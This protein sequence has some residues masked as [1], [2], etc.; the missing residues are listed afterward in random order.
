MGEQ[1][2]TFLSLDAFLEWEARQT[3][4]HEFV[5][6]VARMMT[7]G[8]LRHSR[9]AGLAFAAFDRRLRG[10][11]CRPTTSDFM[12]VLP[13]G[14]GR[15]PDVTVVC[16]PFDPADRA[17]RSPVAIVEILSPSTAAYDQN[18]ELAAYREI[19][20]LQHVLILHRDEPRADLWT[21]GAA[22]GANGWTVSTYIGLASPVP[23]PG[24]AIELPMAELHDEADG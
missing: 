24:L 13:N 6:G 21:R 10:G 16:P 23:L 11:P 7:G 4:R 3:T 17:T 15:Y 8:T 1:K 12:V 20:A 9:M 2:L 19:A 14:D 22:L 18:R 5:D